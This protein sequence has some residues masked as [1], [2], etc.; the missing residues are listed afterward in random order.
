M[1]GP[2]ITPFLFEGEST[3]R[4]IQNARDERYVTVDLCRALG[5]QNP[6]QA[7]EGL[8]DDERGVCSVYTPVGPQ[9][10]L[11]VTEGGMFTII[12]RCRDAMKKGT[13]PYRF[14]RW[15]T[16]EVLPVLRSQGQCVVPADERVRFD[17]PEAIKLRMVSHCRLVWG[18]RAAAELWVHQGL[19][20]MPSMWLPPHQADLFMTWNPSGTGVRAP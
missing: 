18:N 13:L 4:V 19:P 17:L 1:T 20:V 11:T 2:K 14:R 7:V 5:I 15:V 8:E 9:Q 10:I 16:N 12:L 3:V 6:A